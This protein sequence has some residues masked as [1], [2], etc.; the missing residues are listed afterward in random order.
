MTF[1]AFSKPQAGCTE[2]GAIVL[3]GGR[4]LQAMVGKELQPENGEYVRLVQHPYRKALYQNSIVVGLEDA[5]VQSVLDKFNKPIATQAV[6]TALMGSERWTD[7]LRS[8]RDFQNFGYMPFDHF[9]NR[10]APIVQWHWSTEDGDKMALMCNLVKE[11]C[12][13]VFYPFYG[14]GMD[15]HY[16]NIQSAVEP[17]MW[18]GGKADTDNAYRD[19]IDLCPWDGLTV[20]DFEHYGGPTTPFH[21]SFITL[22][23]CGDKFREFKNKLSIVDTGSGYAAFMPE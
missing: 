5:N 11:W 14:L 6:H 23:E 12:G 22:G 18:I 3:Y 4:G 15:D 10:A 8:E 16:E 9:I 21:L 19:Q 2:V 1:A 17:H 13:E 7:V 20:D